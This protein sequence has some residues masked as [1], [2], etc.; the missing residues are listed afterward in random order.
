MKRLVTLFLATILAFTFTLK[1]DAKTKVVEVPENP[2]VIEEE[3]TVTSEGG[4][5]DVGFATIRFKK[6]FL[7]D[8]SLPITFKVSMYAEDGEVYIE[9]SPD[10]EQ[11]EKFVSVK[12]KN[13]SGYIYDVSLG[14]NI[15]VEVPSQHLKV[16]H[17][18][19]YCWAH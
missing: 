6:G 8:D 19:R 17:F 7:D 16:E 10:I 13:F 4:K 14:E 3:I 12:A 11:F 2:L 1:L 5:F 15:Y 18:S 9:F